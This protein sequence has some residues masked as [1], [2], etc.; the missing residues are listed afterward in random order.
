M[1]AVNRFVFL[2]LLLYTPK[3]IVAFKVVLS[4]QG[5]GT[6]PTTINVLVTDLQLDYN[7]IVHLVRSSFDRY[8]NLVNLNLDDNGV[9][10]V[11]SDAF[12]ANNVLEL[13]K[14]DGHNLLAVPDGF[15]GLSDTLKE[16][17]LDRGMRPMQAVTFAHYPS[18]EVIVVT[19]TAIQGKITIEDCPNVREVFSQSSTLTTFPDFS[20]V[21]KV[22]IIQLHYNSFTHIPVEFVAGLTKLYRFAIPQCKLPALP[23]LSHMVSLNYLQFDGNEFQSLPDMYDLPLLEMDIANNPLVCDKALCW[24]RMWNMLKPYTFPTL[25]KWSG[26]PSKCTIPGDAAAVLILSVHPVKMGCYASNALWLFK[27][28]YICCNVSRLHLFELADCSS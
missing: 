17:H 19:D 27:Q 26:G 14:L 28:T 12:Y 21:P 13:L 23:D 7:N 3:M 15:G 6:V 20:T 11:D 9:H 10:T 4:G 1:L 18:L 22:E 8:V 24:I 5:Y 25:E 16:I 2:C